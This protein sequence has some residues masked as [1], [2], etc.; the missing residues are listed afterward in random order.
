MILLSPPPTTGSHTR[1][2]MHVLDNTMLDDAVLGIQIRGPCSTTFILYFISLTNVLEI[3][4][5][6]F[7]K[8]ALT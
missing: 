8:V 4:F 7:R 2:W 6:N 1:I 5:L 3:L